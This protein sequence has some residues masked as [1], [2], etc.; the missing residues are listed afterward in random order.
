MTME[1]I[2][3]LQ[4]AKG[5]EAVQCEITIIGRLDGDDGDVARAG[6]APRLHSNWNQSENPLASCWSKCAF[7]RVRLLATSTG[8]GT[9]APMSS[10]H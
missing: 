7:G 6:W 4:R 2:A 5:H 8:T 9:A 10:V 1:M 3:E